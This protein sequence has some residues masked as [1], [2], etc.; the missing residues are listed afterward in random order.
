MTTIPQPADPTNSFSG[1]FD[2]WNRLVELVDNST[3]DTVQRYQYDGRN[4]SIVAFTRASRKLSF[5]PEA[6]RVFTS[7]SERGK[8]MVFWLFP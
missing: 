5:A 4:Y 2:A 3:S 7:A 6:R 8:P 1:T